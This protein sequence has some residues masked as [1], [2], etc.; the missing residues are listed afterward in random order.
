MDVVVTEFG[1]SLGKKSERL[2]IRRKGAVIEEYPL[3]QVSHVIVASNGVALSS[4]LVRICAES[5][6]PISFISGSGKPIARL[7]SPE[8]VGSVE[9]RR[10]QMMSYLDQRG[11]EFALA[12]TRAKIANQ[13]AVLK[14]F[15]KSRKTTHPELYSLLHA[16]ARRVTRIAS[17]LDLDA[18]VP[19]PGHLG[20]GRLDPRFGP[21]LRITGAESEDASPLEAGALQ[22]GHLVMQ[23][24][25]A[26]SDPGESEAP[27]APGETAGLSETAPTTT[28][29]SNPGLDRTSGWLAQAEPVGTLE[30]CGPRGELGPSTR[31]TFSY[32]DALPERIDFLRPSILSIEGRAGRAYWEALKQIV[33]PEL[34]FAS[35][36]H[37]GATDLT[38]SLLNYG[39]GMLYQQVWGAIVLA[40]LDPFAGFLHVDRPGKP[41]L[42]L[43]LVEEFRQTV[44]DRTVFGLLT[45]GVVYKMTEEGRLADEARKEYACRII[46]RLDA[47]VKYEGKRER[48]RAVIQKQ[49]RHLACYFRGE[50]GYSGYVGTW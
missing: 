31:E 39:Y 2:V 33:P 41:S 22:R 21:P 16:A 40:G 13:A 20:M 8:M 37:Q 10:R 42:V 11:V 9:T 12:I 25:D 43:D 46:D 14:Y 6:I 34:G 38:N 47:P 44:V 29:E 3:F 5:G 50:R 23:W 49:A 48:L 32:E 18:L 1:V 19:D 4:D 35:R 15:G 7:S 27:D 30:A 28:S 17:E 36:S 24:P 26:L 45:K